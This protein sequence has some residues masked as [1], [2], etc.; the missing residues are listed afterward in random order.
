[1]VDIYQARP[2]LMRIQRKLR[3]ECLGRA[4]TTLL[5]S[6]L[7]PLIETVARQ[8]VRSDL[9]WTLPMS[10]WSNWPKSVDSGSDASK[11]GPFWDQ[12]ERMGP[13]G[14]EPPISSL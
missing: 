7:L 2:T 3:N 10:H 8:T 4:G 12:T 1:M 11:Y 9:G 5:P 14:V 13:G 6:D